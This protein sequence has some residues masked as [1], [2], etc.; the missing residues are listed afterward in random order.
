MAYIIASQPCV[1]TGAMFL[2]LLLAAPLSLIIGE[3]KAII[4]IFTSN[5]HV[6]TYTSDSVFLATPLS[7]IPAALYL[8]R[9]NPI[10]LSTCMYTYIA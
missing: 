7:S 1:F 10:I 8:S 5:V 2:L 3:L 9:I 6:L 4:I